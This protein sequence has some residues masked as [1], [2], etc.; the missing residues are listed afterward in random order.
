M[1]KE[2]RFE[3][4]PFKKMN[5]ILNTIHFVPEG[6]NPCTNCG[7]CNAVCPAGIDIPAVI[8]VCK[9]HE[10]IEML[11]ELAG[12]EDCIECGACTS[13][14]PEKI[15]VKDLMRELAMQQC[16]HGSPSNPYPHGVSPPTNRTAV[17]S[18]PV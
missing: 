1:G 18:C 7:R 6:K 10:K 12:P 17:K 8:G 2:N 15:A 14:C 9:R 13:C 3:M 16:L 5:S 11:S 4:R